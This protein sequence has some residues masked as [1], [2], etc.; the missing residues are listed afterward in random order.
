MKLIIHQDL[1]IP[2]TE[3]TIRCSGMDSRLEHLIH[4]IR[5][6]GF[7]LTGYQEDKEYQLPLDQ[8]Y[9]IDSADGKTF[10]YLEKEVYSCRETLS[11]LAERLSFTSFARI[12]KSCLVNTCYLKSVRPLYNHRLE[13]ALRNGEKLIITRNYIEPL[14]EKLKGE[15]L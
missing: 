10:L 12:S 9:F 14:K 2:E 8:I 3:I 11:S 6:Y 15:M 5:Q 1:Q 7:S 13:A 4:Q